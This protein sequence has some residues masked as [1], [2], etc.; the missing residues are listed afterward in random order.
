M[1]CGFCTP[2]IV[3]S[4]VELLEREPDPS[5]EAIADVLGGHLCRCTG[6]VKIREAAEEAVAADRG[7]VMT[8]VFG[9]PLKRKEDPRLLR[10]DGRYLADLKAHGMLAA[11]IVR[12]PHPHA[13]IRSVDASAAREDPADGRG[14]HRG[15]PAGAAAAALHRCRGDDEAVQP[16]GDR[17]GQGALRRRAGGGRGRRGPLRGGGRRRAGRRRLRTAPRGCRRRA[18]DGAG[19]PDRPRGDQR[20]RH[21]RIQDR[22]PA[23]PRSRR[24]RTSSPSASRPSATP[25]CRWRRAARSPTGTR[26]PRRS[27]S[28]ARPR[29]RTRSSATSARA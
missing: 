14:A 11:A 29:C 2:G 16:A 19:R 13:L 12:S 25:G 4:L 5:G 3:M 9:A 23:T 6:Y 27:R 8:A 26:A 21:P 24:P 22:R 20:L 17:L 10:G 1:Q 28:R 18:G 7:G 15:R